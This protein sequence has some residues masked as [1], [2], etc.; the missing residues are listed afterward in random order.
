MNR[1]KTSARHGAVTAIAFT[2]KR[3]VAFIVVIAVVLIAMIGIV[4]ALVFGGN[5]GLRSDSDVPA[6]ARTSQST[7]GGS[8]AI[9]VSPDGEGSMDFDKAVNGG[10]SDSSADADSASSSQGTGSARNESP[11]GSAASHPESDSMGFGKMY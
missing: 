5:N 2:G 3:G 8:P 7:N 6:P 10:S 9:T 1:K 11:D 4:C